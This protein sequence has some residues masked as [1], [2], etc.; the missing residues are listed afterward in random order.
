MA[1][2]AKSNLEMIQQS[3]HDKKNGIKVNVCRYVYMYV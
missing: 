3:W 1:K 2:A